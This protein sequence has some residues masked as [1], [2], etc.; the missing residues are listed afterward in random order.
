MTNLGMTIAARESELSSYLAKQPYQIEQD[1]ISLTIAKNVFPSDFG[2]TSSFFGRFMLRQSP[3][4]KGL[5]MGCG[6]GYFAFILKKIGCEQVVGVDFNADAVLCAQQNCDLN[7]D[8]SPDLF[9]HS[10]L[11]ASVPEHRF[12]IVVF[13]FNYYPSHGMFGLNE[14]GGQE[15]LRRFFRQVS[16]YLEDGARIYIPF[17]EFVG[18]EHDPK[19]IAPEFDFTVRTV[20]ETYNSAGWHWIYQISRE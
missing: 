3:A 16:P 8:L 9:I 15:I 12:G 10:D 7:P 17:S 20:A 4:I 19:N 5:D 14:D 1:G 13:N 18:A 2:M 11:F 6:S